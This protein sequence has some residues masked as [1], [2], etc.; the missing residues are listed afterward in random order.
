MNSKITKRRQQWRKSQQR[1][2][3]KQGVTPRRQKREQLRAWI[4]VKCPNYKDTGFGHL[5]NRTDKLD[6]QIVSMYLE[7]ETMTAIAA[8]VNRHHSV[9]ASRLKKIARLLEG[10]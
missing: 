3:L 9:V 4:D 6:A 1:R 7:G 5:S 10:D 8:N 2:R